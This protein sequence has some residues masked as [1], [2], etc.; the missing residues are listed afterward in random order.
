MSIVS[1]TKAANGWV[2]ANDAARA[3]HAKQRFGALCSADFKQMRNERFHRKFFALLNLAFEYWDV[4]DGEYKCEPVA[5]NFER[6]RKDVTI[7]AGYGEPVWNIRGELR[8][9]AKSISF[10]SMSKEDFDAL[11]SR[12]VDV[13]LSRVLTAKGFDRTQVDRIV[14]Q[15][16]EFA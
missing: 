4:A 11:Y 7:L 8:M 16:A 13:L 5:K 9:E 14:D 10:A 12:A 2:P 15:I 1:V 3:I 6:F